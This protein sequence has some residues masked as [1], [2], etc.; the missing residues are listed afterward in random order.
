MMDGVLV[1]DAVEI[2]IDLASS[3]IYGTIPTANMARN[4]FRDDNFTF[5]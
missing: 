4:W 3:N 5:S 2:V 1:L